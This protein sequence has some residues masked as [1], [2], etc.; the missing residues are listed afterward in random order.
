VLRFLALLKTKAFKILLLGVI[1]GMII[2]ALFS[3]MIHFTTQ[4]SFCISCHEMRIVAEQGWMQSIHYK[5]KSGI[6]AQCSDCHIEPEL[7]QMLWTKT[8]DGLNDIWVHNTGESDPY[9]MDWEKLSQVAREHSSDS[10]CKRCHSNIASPANASIKMII[11]HRAYKRMNGRKK[12]VD[13]HTTEFH[14]EFKKYLLR[15]STKKGMPDEQ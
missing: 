15:N 7:L 8:R 13:C 11:A 3:Y 9:K 12:C 4:S 6:I 14:G 2:L 10:S 5:N 1:S